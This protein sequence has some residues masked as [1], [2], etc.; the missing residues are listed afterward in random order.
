MSLQVVSENAVRQ[1]KEEARIQEACGHHS[2]IAGAVSRWQT[3]KRLY[4]GKHPFLIQQ[5]GE[6]D[7]NL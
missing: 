7:Y 2:F 1:V 4:I 6:E 3:K 5:E